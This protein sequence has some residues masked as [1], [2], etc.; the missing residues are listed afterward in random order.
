MEHYWQFMDNDEFQCS[1]CSKFGSFDLAENGGQC[2]PC[3]IC[4]EIH[5]CD[6]R[7]LP[8][9]DCECCWLASK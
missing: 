1:K 4:N 8:D 6:E 2:E 3:V 5:T 7:R 9:G